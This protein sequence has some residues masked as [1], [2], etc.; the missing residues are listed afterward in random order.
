[1]LM[2]KVRFR[3]R[4]RLGLDLGLVKIEF[5]TGINYLVPTKIEIQNCVLVCVTMNAEQSWRS[6]QLF[7]RN[8]VYFYSNEGVLDLR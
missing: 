4:F 1:M 7:V 2:V 8:T 6:P 5:R 3:L